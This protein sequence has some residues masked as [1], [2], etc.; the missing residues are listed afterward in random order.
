MKKVYSE[1]STIEC[2]PYH[3][4]ITARTCELRYHKGNGPIS[5]QQWKKV[6]DGTGDVQ[7]CKNCLIGQSVERQLIALRVRKAASN[8]SADAAKAR[9][10][11]TSLAA[12]AVKARDTAQQ[13]ESR[14]KEFELVASRAAAQAEADGEFIV[15][16]DALEA[17]PVDAS[18][19]TIIAAKGVWRPR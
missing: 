2:K 8:L 18:S 11:A 1:L 10:A 16:D 4:M 14:A 17:I 6:R 19:S 5:S 12:E 15:E 13:M 9:E 3:A 7:G